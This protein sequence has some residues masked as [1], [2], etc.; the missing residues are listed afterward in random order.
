MPASLNSP[1]TLQLTE[2]HV[3]LDSKFRKTITHTCMLDVAVRFVRG[4]L[5]PLN[6]LK[7]SLC[8]D[9]TGTWSLSEW[10][11]LTSGLKNQTPLFEV[12]TN[13]KKKKGRTA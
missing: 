6:R 8:W 1:H 9:V 7:S 5:L 4:L 12:A 11:A 10:R 3:H 13:A 2:L